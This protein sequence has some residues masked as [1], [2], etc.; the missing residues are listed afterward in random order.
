M[1]ISGFSFKV[2][3]RCWTYNHAP[4]ISDVLGGVVIQ[5]TSFPYICII[6]D[7]ASTDGGPSVIRNYLSDHFDAQDN[8]LVQ[9]EETDDYVFSFARHKTNKNCYF[10]VFLLKYNHH[11]KINKGR[12]FNSWANTIQLQ[13]MCEGDDYWT[14]PLKLQKQV[15][16][17]E[18][19]PDVTLCCTACQIRT[20][21]AIET[22]RR[23][24]HNCI[25]PTE[26]III[27][28][29]L[30]LHTVTF[31]YRKSLTDNYPD[32][33]RSCHVGDYPLILWA[34]LNGSVYYLPE[35]TAVYRYQN[36]GSW[37]S[38]RESLGIDTLIRGWKSEVKMLQ[39]LDDYS[40]GKYSAT[41]KTRIRTYLYDA[42]VNHP[43]NV[44]QIVSEFREEVKLFTL[45]QKVHVLCIQMHIE[46][47]YSF[48]WNRWLLIKRRSH[49]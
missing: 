38:R 9:N 46:P 23:Y 21:D 44:R 22:Q 13:A 11:G 45:R 49:C 7:D 31:M 5:K 33:C 20:G 34:S 42:V 10:A 24:N 25:V 26:D 6:V 19:H 27:G 4:Y 2:C 18:N 32:Y 39:G 16:L 47:V 12:Y 8:T 35:E 43:Q 37:T 1:D 14:D 17:F 30:W 29:G 15:D 28:G 36:S 3:I 40:G 48:L 41:F